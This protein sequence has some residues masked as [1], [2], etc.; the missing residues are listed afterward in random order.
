VPYASRSTGFAVNDALGVV[1]NLPASAACAALD[2]VVVALVGHLQQDP[3]HARGDLADIF[4]LTKV[5]RSLVVSGSILT[6]PTTS[7]W[8]YVSKLHAH[9]ARQRPST[10]WDQGIS[11]SG[12]TLA[13]GQP[14]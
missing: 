4:A 8:V 12:S 3:K 11:T 6:R 1:R 7:G 9:V 2:P 14:S 10:S 13:I 5:F